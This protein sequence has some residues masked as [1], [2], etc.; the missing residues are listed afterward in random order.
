MHAASA[1]TIRVQQVFE[2]QRRLTEQGFGTLL[3]QTGQTA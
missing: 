1:I 3:L 2:L